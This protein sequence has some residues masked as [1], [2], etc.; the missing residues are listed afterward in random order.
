MR[1]SRKRT[2]T[3]NPSAPLTT[4]VISPPKPL[5]SDLPEQLIAARAYEM[6][7]RR[8][9]PMGQDA[10]RDWYAARAELEQERLGWATPAPDDRDRGVDE[11]DIRPTR[12]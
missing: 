5:S 1:F 3:P 7:Q 8:G 12:S 11:E 2:R 10:A 6:W 9:C 4:D